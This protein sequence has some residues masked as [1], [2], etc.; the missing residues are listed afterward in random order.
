MTAAP[1]AAPPASTDVLVVGAGIAG[2]ALAYELA[3]R[4]V[5]CLLVEHERPGAGASGVPV[6]LINPHRGRSA[7]ASAA[8]LE[9]ARAFWELTAA[10]ERGGG[11]SG[12][13]RS[14]VLRV[15]DQERQ[16][17]AWRRL[18]QASAAARWLE[19]AEVPAPYHA[20]HGALLVEGGGWADTRALLSALT[21][22]AQG[23]GATLRTG[24]ALLSL[25]AGAGAPVRALLE[26]RA[27]GDE[28]RRQVVACRAAVVATGAW[29]PPGVRLPR[30]ELVWG[31][32]LVLDLAGA[33]TPPYPLAGGAVAA[34]P[35]GRAVITGGHRS[36]PAPDA[37]PASL[38]GTPA[39]ARPDT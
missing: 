23:H 18:A 39:G 3:R 8:D 1:A 25:E 6:A 16:A 36:V 14:G 13:R 35:G 11:V 28:A 4:G 27:P 19:P 33:P 31:A 38:P 15:P 30:F 37:A 9:G 2:S 21:A 26:T 34:F 20:P 32:A 29:Q 17:R 10:L 5:D 24:T 7:R 22:A 12:A